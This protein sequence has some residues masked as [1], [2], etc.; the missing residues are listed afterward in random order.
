MR[1]APD[2]ISTCMEAGWPSSTV[3]EAVLLAMAD[4]RAKD[5]W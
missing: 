2:T 5:G 1:A 4:V 3:A